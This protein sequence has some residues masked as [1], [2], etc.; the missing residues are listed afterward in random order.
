MTLRGELGGNLAVVVRGV[1]EF[2]V[3]RE[4]FTDRSGDSFSP[5]LI[6]GRGEIGMSWRVQ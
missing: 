3:L 1:A 2:N 5:S 4:S 6:V